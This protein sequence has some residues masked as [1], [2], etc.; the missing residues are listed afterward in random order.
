MT[1]HRIPLSR[2]KKEIEI[3]TARSGGSGGQNV[4]KV[5][6]KVVLRF[7][8][9]ESTILTDKQKAIIKDKLSTKLT[10][11]DELII[12]SESSR[13]QLK[14]KELAFKKLDRL[15]TKAFARKKLRK[16]TKP[17]KASKKK[18]LD[19]KKKQGEK[20]KWRQKPE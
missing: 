19:S 17:T 18:R 7:N 3:T 8:V 6:T 5:E 11:D 15:L 4:N 16:A 20:K 12:T 1:I 13:S 9:T 10:K 14:N 2:L